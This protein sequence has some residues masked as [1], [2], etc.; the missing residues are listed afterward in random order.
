M[1]DE[2]SQP[3]I[4]CPIDLF[5]RQEREAMRWNEE[6]N[7]ASTAAEKSGPA[8]SLIETVDVLLACAHYDENDVNCRLCRNIAELRRKVASLI[9]SAGRL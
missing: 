8:Q 5:P 1:N 7:R 6:I 2:R 9:V 3:R 4:R